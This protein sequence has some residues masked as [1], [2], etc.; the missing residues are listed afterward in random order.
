M[1][2]RNPV[3]FVFSLSLTKTAQRNLVMMLNMEYG[4]DVHIGLVSVEGVVSHD[5][6]HMSPKLIAERAWQLYS[7]EKG[8]WKLEIEINEE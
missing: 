7:Q 3:T 8:D 1:L 2:Y 6:E 5:K 4:K